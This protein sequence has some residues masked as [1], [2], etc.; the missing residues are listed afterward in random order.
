[1]EFTVNKSQA[2]GNIEHTQ[3]IF[4]HIITHLQCHEID[5]QYIYWLMCLV[6]IMTSKSA[7]LVPN[8]PTNIQKYQQFE[9]RVF[10][11]TNIT[12][13]Y[14]VSIW[15]LPC[16]LEHTNKYYAIQ[17]NKRIEQRVSLISGS[18]QTLVSSVRS[19]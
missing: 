6:M 7:H 11:L 8:S 14:N 19:I 2:L 13:H 9:T 1:M 10:I 3:S 12:K 4:K 18:T 16:Q 17:T 15:N 5:F